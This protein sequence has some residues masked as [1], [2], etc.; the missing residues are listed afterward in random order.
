MDRNLTQLSRQMLREIFTELLISAAGV[1]WAQSFSLIY[2]IDASG[3]Y[4]ILHSFNDHDGSL[5][6]GGVTRDDAGNVYG[7]TVV[8]GPSHQGVVFKLTSTG[9][10]T[11]LHSFG[12]PEG[13]QP[14]STLV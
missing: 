6:Y 5:P 9:Q 1:I 14:E 13:A 4:T 3:R 10:Y 8:G 2:R 7:T 12:G 11:V